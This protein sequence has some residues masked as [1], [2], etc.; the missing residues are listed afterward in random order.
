MIGDKGGKPDKKSINKKLPNPD[1]KLKRKI[2]ALLRKRYFEKKVVN[3]KP[4]NPEGVIGGK[5]ML[6]E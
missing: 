2:S 3:E 6:Y 5:P 4:L 1:G